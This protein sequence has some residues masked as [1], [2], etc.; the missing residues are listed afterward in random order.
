MI[1]ESE[2]K[3]MLEVT[4]KDPGLG[5]SEEDQKRLFEPFSKTSNA[6]S[7]S[8]NVYGNGVGLSICK[9]ICEGLEGSIKVDSQLGFGSKFTFSMSVY[10]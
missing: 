7:R 4:V 6:K 10:R 8:M 5:I 1:E 9:Q 2:D 3:L